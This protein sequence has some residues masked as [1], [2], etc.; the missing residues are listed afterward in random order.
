MNRSKGARLAHSR[1]TELLWLDVETGDFI[2]LK[3]QRGLRA[4]TVAGHKHKATGYIQIR[5]DG[6][7]Y[8]AHRLAWFYCYGEWPAEELDHENNI[9]TDNRPCNLRLASRSQNSANKAKQAPGTSE[10]KGVSWHPKGQKWQARV[11]IRKQ[12]HYLGLFDDPIAAARAYDEKARD[13]FG[14]F[15]STNFP[16]EVA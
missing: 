5:I 10:F 7:L 8:L 12:T 13:L 6:Y 3:G 11:Q 16:K 9:K 4:G 14:P 2:R 15:A 1:L